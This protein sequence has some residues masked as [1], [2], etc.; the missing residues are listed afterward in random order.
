MWFLTGVRPKTRQLHPKL[1]VGE[2]SKLCADQWKTMTEDEKLPWV[3][4]ATNDKTR[5]A[6]EMFF[7]AN[8]NT[9]PLGRG[10]RQK[11]RSFNN[12]FL[13]NPHSVTPTAANI[14]EH[15][16]HSSNEINSI[17]I[18]NNNNNNN[19][20]DHHDKDNSKINEMD[21]N[22]NNNHSNEEEI[23]KIRE[24]Q[25]HQLE[26]G[27]STNENDINNSDHHHQNQQVSIIHNEHN[28]MNQNDNGNINMMNDNQSTPNNNYHHPDKNSLE[29]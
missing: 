27:K 5:Y 14:P 2:I 18:N 24:N 19:I 25:H 11:Y 23:E 8:Q 26:K 10:T 16:H 21:E 15:H 12:P 7:Y 28:N 22:N 9:H 6:R 13:T 17:G 20:H 29:N 3:E 4:K 1:T